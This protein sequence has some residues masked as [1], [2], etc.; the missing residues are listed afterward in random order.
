[1]APISPQSI[2]QQQG[3][4]SYHNIMLVTLSYHSKVNLA[5]PLYVDKLA[6]AACLYVFIN[7]FPASL[8]N[9]ILHM[10][11]IESRCV[12]IIAPIQKRTKK[13]IFF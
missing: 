13:N 6:E 5:G 11:A 12:Q 9:Q 7:R 3:S 10:R 8:F 2:D 4:T 1:M